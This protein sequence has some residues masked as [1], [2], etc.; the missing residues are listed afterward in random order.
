MSLFDQLSGASTQ[1]RGQKITEPELNHSIDFVVCTDDIKLQESNR[2]MGTMM[3]HEFTIAR[4]TALNPPGS[5]RSWVQFPTHRTQTDPGNIKMFVAAHL[6]ITDDNPE[7]PPEEFERATQGAFNG[8]LIALNVEHIQTQSGRDFYVHT[9]RPFLGTLTE[10]EQAAMNAQAGPADKDEAP[11]P[12]APVPPAPAPQA[13]PQAL[14]RESW[15]AGAGPGTQHP[16]NPAYE[17]NPQQPDWGCRPK[18]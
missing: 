12:A 7:I 17:W 1:G 3:I 16:E 13:P 5:S 6:G 9:W 2:G 15:L 14:T 10:E 8:K 11:R 18:R 4:G